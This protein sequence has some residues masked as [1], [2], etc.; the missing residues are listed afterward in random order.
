MDRQRL[1][2]L[3]LDGWG[4][5]NTTEHNAT[6]LSNPENFNRLIK[7]DPWVTLDASEEH[8]GLPAGQMGNSEVG[9]TNIGAGRVVYQDLLKIT[10]AFQSG[11]ADSNDT[12]IDF[13][14]SVKNGSGRLHLAGLMSDGGVHSHI[15]HFK[16]VINAAR[17]QGI[18]EIYIH[19]FTDGRDTPP[20][21]GLDY[22]AELSIWTEKY[23]VAKIA[24]VCGR[25]YAMDR[26]KRWDRVER[27]YNMLRNGAGAKAH[28]VLSAVQNM[29]AR[30]LTDEFIEPTIIEGVDG[31]IK[32][33]D[34]LF[35]MNFRAD[36]MRELLQVFYADSFD[37]FDRGAK[38]NLHLLTMTDYD[39]SMPAPAMFPGESLEHLL[40]E[41][42][43]NAGLSQLRIAETEKYAHVTYFFNGGREEPFAGEERIL[44]PSPREVATYDLKPQM[45]VDEVAD[46]FI[47]RFSKGDIDLAVMNFANPDMV[48]H[49][50]IEEAAIAAC[51]YVDS[52]L[53]RVIELADRMNAVLFVTADHGN[54]EQMWDEKNNQPQTAHTTNPV[55]LI[56]HNY[57]C[58]INRNRGKLAD[59]APTALK[60]LQLPQPI[61]MDGVSL[62]D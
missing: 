19:P 51:K 17:A 20:T 15:N 54:S 10:R 55:R 52:A 32:D 24:D 2:L 27:A 22:L 56:I 25:F 16:F 37:G 39:S 43:S 30:T 29:Y 57:K 1:I 53:G 28:D 38:P 34:G 31:T 21:S 44:V 45:S 50:G 14:K 46:K 4:Y 9:H 58:T 8:V 18:K 11:V 5:I 35:L 6:V 62:I 60:I 42:I 61:S 3:I 7:N 40:G 36:R 13:I 48:G 47:E 41:E 23:Q 12:F 49:T 26:D 59:I 33:G